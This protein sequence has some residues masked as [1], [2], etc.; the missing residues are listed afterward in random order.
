MRHST[1]AGGVRAGSTVPGRLNDGGRLIGE[2][3]TP[4]GRAFFPGS[5]PTFVSAAN[6][7][8]PAANTT[9]EGEIFLPLRDTI[10]A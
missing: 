3:A 2:C 7:A 8:G 10:G 4:A 6:D 1:Q 9:V 5:V